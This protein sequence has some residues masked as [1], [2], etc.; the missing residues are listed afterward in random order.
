[1][2][3]PLTVGVE[4]EFFLISPDGGS[5]EPSSREVLAAVPVTG[6]VQLVKPE[7][8]TAVVEIA[9]DPHS[10]LS[11]LGDNVRWL[12]SVAA[13]A[14]ESA[15]CAVLACGTEPVAGP[16]HPPSDGSR[17]RGIHRK[18][19]DLVFGHMPCGLHV[20]VG[21]PDRE[22][23]VRVSNHLRPWLPTLQALAGNSPISLG[24]DTGFAS[25]RSMWW[26]YMPVWGPAP[27][28]SG[29]DEYNA[30]LDR[31]VAT[32]VILDR[33]MAY[34]F[35]RPSEHVPT[36]E[37]RV[38][39]VSPTSDTTVLLA[40]LVRALVATCLRE[41]ERGTPPPSVSEQLLVA[42]HWQ[43]AREGLEGGAVDLT[44]GRPAPAWT[45]VDR[46]L[47]HI[48]PALAGTGD[49]PLVSGLLADLRTNGS[50]AERQRG[51]IRQGGTPADV[52]AH[53]SSLFLK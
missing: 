2:V 47:T 41:V 9:T 33:K 32:G 13:T 43:A 34:W 16:Y 26:A 6:P 18:Y 52:A 45:T 38:M 25:W 10:D 37:V 30:L 22:H 29:V 53:L 3:E 49:L 42:A 35:A 5:V 11:L 27:L 20:H 23:A 14:A 19:G 4:E 1:M 17:F 31:L 50:W 36:V 28:F 39:D 8:S 12:R 7:C 44:T 15:G 46:L 40:G 21:M 51:T 48:T 24:E